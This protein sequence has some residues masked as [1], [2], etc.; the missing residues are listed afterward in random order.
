MGTVGISPPHPLEN[1]TRTNS[2]NTG[3]NFLPLRLVLS[4]TRYLYT[5]SP[6]H[7]CKSEMGVIFEGGSYGRLLY[8]YA[9]VVWLHTVVLCQA[10]LPAM[11]P[12]I[13]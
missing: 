5:N 9:D 10:P 6:L 2:Y 7:Q 3:P 1:N 13:I 11:N 12:T 8:I 4:R